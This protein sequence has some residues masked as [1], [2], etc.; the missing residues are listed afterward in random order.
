[1]NE[2]FLMQYAKQYIQ[3]AIQQSE[4]VRLVAEARQSQS[5]QPE[6]QSGVRE[7]LGQK[8]IDFGSQLK[9]DCGCPGS[10]SSRT[11]AR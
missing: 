1:M 5:E 11:V 6:H 10:L 3:E 8:M 9:G 7:W 4:N 2:R